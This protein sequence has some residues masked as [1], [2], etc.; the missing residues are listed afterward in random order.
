MM[1][2]SLVTIIFLMIGICA[3]VNSSDD[4]KRKQNQRPEN[5]ELIKLP[6]GFGPHRIENTPV[7]YGDRPLLIENSRLSSEKDTSHIT[8]MYIVDL[9]TTEIIARF[10]ID[11]AFHSAY[12]NGNELNVFATENTRDEWTAS[13]YRFWSTDL[14]E[15]NRELVMPIKKGEH[16]FNTSVCK[17]PDGYIMAYE[18]NLP[19]QWCFRLARSR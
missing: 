1:K 3:C 4:A 14:K 12:V 16:F 7:M 5:P 6:I 8:D 15:W 9:T 17:G 19:V 11:F 2:N 13:I 18:S 10:G